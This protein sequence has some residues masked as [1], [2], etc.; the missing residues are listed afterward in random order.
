MATGLYPLAPHAW[1]AWSRWRRDKLPLPRQLR[2]ALREWRVALAASV[3]RP[4]GF[5][6]LAGEHGR[7]PRPIILVHGYVM[8]RANFRSLARRLA[9]AGLG[10][11]LGFEYWSLGRAATAA[12]R[13]ADYIEEVR[14]ATEADQVDVIGHSMGGV[15]ARYYVSLLGGDGVVKHLV[16]IGT[17]HAGTDVSSIGIGRPA[18]ELI[19]NSSLMQR[20]EAASRLVETHLTVIWSRADAL[21]SRA[22]NAR[23]AGVDAADELIYDDLGHM[24]MLVDRR[25]ADAII[26]RLRR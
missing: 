7:G 22:R 11:V 13:L 2:A 6:P 4:L 23:V 25:V 14:A 17:P 12:K 16:T 15:V 5:V 20:L 10:P 8:N 1:L 24:T 9:Q 18:K 3:A 26:E 19:L 21:V